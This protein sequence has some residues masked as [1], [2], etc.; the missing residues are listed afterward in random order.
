ML[1]LLGGL[2]TPVVRVVPFVNRRLAQTNVCVK[3]IG[4]YL[5]FLLDYM[6]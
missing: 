3:K 6:F 2:L 5:L 1:P 4:K